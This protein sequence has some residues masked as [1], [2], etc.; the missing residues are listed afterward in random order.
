MF[1]INFKSLNNERSCRVNPRM[2]PIH[3]VRR[4]G[5]KNISILHSPCRASDLQFSLLLQ[6]HALVFN[7]ENG[8]GGFDVFEVPYNHCL[9]D[10]YPLQSVYNCIP[11]NDKKS[12][13]SWLSGRVLDSRPKGRGF[14][15]HWRH[16]VVVLGQD[17]F[18][19]A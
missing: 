9:N 4:P 2:G 10:I 16:C 8:G 19:L 13:T 3:F 6:T 17:T 1:F 5:D 18:I 14:E 12:F 11:Y 7:K 15:P